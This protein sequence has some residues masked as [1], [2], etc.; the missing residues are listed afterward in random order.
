[1]AEVL[2]IGKLSESRIKEISEQGIEVK[3]TIN[4]DDLNLP[5]PSFGETF[6]FHALIFL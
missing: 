3:E 6:C 2:K 1:M 4:I 5:E